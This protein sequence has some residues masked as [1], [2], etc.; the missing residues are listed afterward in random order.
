[1]SALDALPAIIEINQSAITYMGWWKDLGF[2]H[3][4]R[5]N[6]LIR[7]ALRVWQSTND[8]N[9]GHWSDRK[10]E[11]WA[12]LAFR[13]STQEPLIKRGGWEHE[14]AVPSGYSEE[15]IVNGKAQTLL[16]KAVRS[17]L[18]P[19]WFFLWWWILS[20]K[21]ERH[22]DRGSMKKRLEIFALLHKIKCLTFFPN[23]ST[24][25]RYQINFWVLHQV[26]IDYR[27]E[28]PR[29]SESN[30]DLYNATLDFLF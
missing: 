10:G 7:T 30:F 6:E 1:M 21:L 11:H 24:V 20:E 26:L 14:Q 17:S 19:A 12:V 16:M 3:T 22:R 2:W 13:T 29:R 18:S 8:S 5:W 15:Y 27:S 9:L 23:Y 28:K 25:F 4:R